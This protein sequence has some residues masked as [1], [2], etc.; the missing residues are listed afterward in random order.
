MQKYTARHCVEQKV[1]HHL[2]NDMY[3]TYGTHVKAVLPK[4]ANV[5][6]VYVYLTSGG[7]HIGLQVEIRSSPPKF[8]IDVSV[9]H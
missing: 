9:W 8:A 5:S 3:V 7:A 1:V 4:H 2:E 6:Y